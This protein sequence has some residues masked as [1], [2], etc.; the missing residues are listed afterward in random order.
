M[1]A[2]ELADEHS[3]IKI[4]AKGPIVHVFSRRGWRN[5][6]GPMK[7]LVYDFTRK[8]QPIEERSFSWA[9]AVLDMDPDT[10]MAVI[11]DNNR[12][13]G[14]SW[15]LDLKTGKRRVVSTKSWTLF[16][17]REVAQKWGELTKP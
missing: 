17:K 15:L 1:V 4:F 12:F 6:E 5:A 9:R 10:G 14:R 16:V 2:A 11:N 3:S 8:A 7:Y 13:W